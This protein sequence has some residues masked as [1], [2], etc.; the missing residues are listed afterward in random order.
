MSNL[1][2]HR[3][4]A[5]KKNS[6]FNKSRSNEN[7]IAGQQQRRIMNKS[8][9]HAR[10]S[11][12][13]LH[14][15]TIST[16]DLDSKSASIESTRAIEKQFFILHRI[17]FYIELGWGAH[18]IEWRNFRLDDFP[19]A[20]SSNLFCALD[21]AFIFISPN[22]ISRGYF[23]PLFGSIRSMHEAPDCLLRGQQQ[24]VD[25]LVYSSLIET[26]KASKQMIDGLFFGLTS[27]KR[28]VDFIM[29]KRNNK[30]KSEIHRRSFLLQKTSLVAL[31]VPPARR[32]D[33][34]E[35]TW[36]HFL[37]LERRQLQKCTQ[38]DVERKICL[39]DGQV[40]T[41]DLSTPR[42][43]RRSR[44]HRCREVFALDSECTS[45]RCS[46]TISISECHALF[47]PSSPQHLTNLPAHG[48]LKPDAQL[49]RFV[50]SSDQTN[51]FILWKWRIC[52]S[53]Y[54]FLL[55]NFL[56]H[57]KPTRQVWRRKG[58]RERKKW[59]MS[60]QLMLSR[61]VESQTPKRLETDSI[62][63]WLEI[64]S[65]GRSSFTFPMHLE[66]H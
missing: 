26:L 58:A 15:H 61:S 43:T 3:A 11:S 14:S 65:N 41:D 5:Q 57:W 7:E 45:K 13:L 33:A 2:H 47:S 46:K 4:R 20:K 28:F 38:H 39:G 25:C 24:S 52:K 8:S 32:W 55:F 6:L 27:H 1:F 48:N 40:A 49:E 30:K 31:F 51:F 23:S 60:V 21:C 29:W 54:F 19:T 64:E 12:I 10:N 44:H 53:K 66:R 36:K 34:I 16:V 63:G 17:F 35:C 42:W 37:V 59:N 18:E 50:L 22:S 56:H 62:H 9:I